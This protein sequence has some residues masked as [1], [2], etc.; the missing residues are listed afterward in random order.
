VALLVAA[1][2]FGVAAFMVHGVVLKALAASAR[3]AATNAPRQSTGAA[4]TPAGL[5]VIQKMHDRYAS[6]WY[7]TLSFTEIAEQRSDDG[8]TTSETWWEEAKLPGQLR[9]DLGAPPTDTSKPRRIVVYTPDGEYDKRPGQPVHHTDRRN[10][11]LILGFDVYRQP[12]DRT[13]EELKAEG[14]DLS[15]VRSDTWHGRNVTV[16]G[17]DKQF[18]IDTERQLFVRLIDGDTEAWFDD[19][20][21]LDGGWIAAEVGIK[22]KGVMRLHEVYSNIKANVDLPDAM[23]DPGRLP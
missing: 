12:V 1:T 3:P 13:V 20:R 16:V 6:T 17:G 4:E 11:L 2:T 8:K 21:P 14:F 23:F 5:A 15:K 18:W 10:F 22:N 19:Y 7:S 9:I